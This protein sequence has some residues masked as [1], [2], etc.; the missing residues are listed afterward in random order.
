MYQWKSLRRSLC[1][2]RY[3]PAW[4]LLSLALAWLGWA[5]RSCLGDASV[6]RAPPAAI[7]AWDVLGVMVVAPLIEAWMLALV[8][9]LISCKFPA[10]AA[11]LLAAI[12]MAGLHALFDVAWGAMVL[13]PFI[14]FALPFPAQENRW[15]AT[16]MS[17]LIHACHNG[18]ALLAFSLAA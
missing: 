6:R 9:R 13:L 14:V 16:A 4:A 5:L 17:A 3:A 7:A 11:L 15:R 10:A 2:Y 1:L 12:S 8:Y 18:Y